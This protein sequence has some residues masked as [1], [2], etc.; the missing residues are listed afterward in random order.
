MKIRQA[1][2]LSLSTDLHEVARTL[3][4]ADDVLLEAAQSIGSVLRAAPPELAGQGIYAL[5]EAVLDNVSE[6]GALV[7]EARSALTG[8]GPERLLPRPSGQ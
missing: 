3:K 1:I 7:I 6:G 5:L 2:A 4:D 8:R